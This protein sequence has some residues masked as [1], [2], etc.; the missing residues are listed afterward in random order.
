MLPISDQYINSIDSQRQVKMKTDNDKPSQIG[1]RHPSP[2]VPTFPAPSF[3][4]ILSEKEHV[5]AVIKKF[6]LLW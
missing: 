6:K 4:R 3:E 2:S 1:L 5:V